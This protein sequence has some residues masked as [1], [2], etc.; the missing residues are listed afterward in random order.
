MLIS[1]DTLNKRPQIP[2][3]YIRIVEAPLLTF[4]IELKNKLFREAVPENF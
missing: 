3:T 2:V 4:K 1:I